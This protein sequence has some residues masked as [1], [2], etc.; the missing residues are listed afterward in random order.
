MRVKKSPPSSCGLRFSGIFYK[1]LRIL[2][3]LFIHILH[4]P[5]YARLQIFIQLSP[6]LTKLCHITRDYLVH[7]IYS[8]CPP[9]AETRAFRRFATVVDSFVDS[10]LW[11]VIPRGTVATQ[12]RCGGMFSNHLTTNFSRNAAVKK[13]LKIGQ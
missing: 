12:L 9:S 10:C 5:T 4:V 2:N 1:R 6:T 7:I 3:Q 13:I 8:K 11:Q